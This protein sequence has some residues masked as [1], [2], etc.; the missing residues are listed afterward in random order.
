MA[1]VVALG[2]TFALAQNMPQQEPRQ[3]PSGMPQT[4]DQ[5]KMPAASSSGVQSDI[6]SAI[7]KDPSLASANINVQVSDKGVDLTGTAP[8]KDAKDKAEQL[9]TAHAGGLP[10]TNHIKV[11]GASEAPK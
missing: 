10:V 4:S 5:G 8:T 2:G 9:A 3:N 7:Q 1:L 11:A 6:Q